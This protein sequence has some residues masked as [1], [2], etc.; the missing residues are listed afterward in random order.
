MTILIAPPL[1][2]TPI[3]RHQHDCFELLKPTLGD[4]KAA[5]I[6]AS[7]MAL[8]PYLDQLYRKNIT[9]L[10]TLANGGI[11]TIHATIA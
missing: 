5:A 4:E 11:E 6:L 2:Q 8:A 7:A 9:L 1:S 3:S 10:S